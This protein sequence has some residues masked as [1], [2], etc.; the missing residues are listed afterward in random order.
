MILYLYVTGNLYANT[1]FVKLRDE[2]FS[3]T[4]NWERGLTLFPTVSIVMQLY[5]VIYLVMLLAYFLTSKVADY[6]I[7]LV[8][9]YR[10]LIHTLPFDYT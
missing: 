4:Y 2:G 6:Y 3:E 1:D 9:T 7:Y 5:Q 10:L 8:V